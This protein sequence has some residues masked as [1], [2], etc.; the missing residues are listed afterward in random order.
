MSG[1][2][3]KVILYKTRGLK[4]DWKVFREAVIT[5]GGADCNTRKVG[6]GHCDKVLGD[7]EVEL[8]VKRTRGY[9]DILTGKEVKK[10]WNTYF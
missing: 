10:R 4:H 1:E 2:W 6:Y 8:L 7:E 5:C 3:F 9:I